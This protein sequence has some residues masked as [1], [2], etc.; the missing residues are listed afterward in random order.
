MAKP[1]QHT[2]IQQALRACM[3]LL[4]YTA[5]SVQYSGAKGKYINRGDTDTAYLADFKKRYIVLR[6]YESTKFN[7]FAF[8]KKGSS[9]TYRPN[10]HNNF[11]IGGTWRSISLNLGVR[12]AL[13]ERDYARYGRTT[14]FD[15]QTHLYYRHKIIDFYGQYYKSFYQ[16]QPQPADPSVSIK[17]P[18]ISTRDFSITIQHVYN[19]RKYSFL[20]PYHQNELQKQSAGSLLVGAGMYNSSVR[21][22][23]AILGA[24]VI[25]TAM[26]RDYRFRSAGSA[27]IGVNAG[28]AYT[29]VIKR[30]FFI[31]GSATLGLGLNFSRM[32]AEGYENLTGAGP[33]VNASLRLAGGYHYGA[34]FAG[35]NYT[36]L[37]TWSTTA[38][39]GYT[40]EAGRGNYRFI[41]ARRFRLPGEYT[42]RLK[43]M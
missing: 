20:A 8:H 32:N 24:H 37:T 26:L 40:Q 12:A 39:K 3:L 18:D 10:E 36:G 7:N 23:S 11:G 27:G 28:Y 19:W 43:R 42:R 38:I 31:G 30:R 15:L 2:T 5:G 9:I 34:W 25:D 1:H 35:I 21:G 6:A 16:D 29:W 14:Q 13:A 33:Q 4:I 17:R 41:V 22:D